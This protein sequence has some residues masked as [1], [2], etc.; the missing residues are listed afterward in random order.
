MLDYFDSAARMQRSVC[1]KVLDIANV[2]RQLADS[3]L[4]GSRQ[5]YRVRN[6]RKKNHLSAHE[7]MKTPACSIW[8]RPH[9]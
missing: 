3:T 8:L 6:R 2:S 1:V 5:V 4:H 7:N 9:T